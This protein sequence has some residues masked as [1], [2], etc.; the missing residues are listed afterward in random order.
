MIELLADLFNVGRA[1]E[2]EMKKYR[3]KNG[4]LGPYDAIYWDGDTLVVELDPRKDIMSPMSPPEI[5]ERIEYQKLG[6]GAILEKR[7]HTDCITKPKEEDIHIMTIN[8]DFIKIPAV[9]E[10][11]AKA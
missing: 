8:Q 1:V 5:F 7:Y 6:G 4:G 11:L 3:K 9:R 10:E 2:R